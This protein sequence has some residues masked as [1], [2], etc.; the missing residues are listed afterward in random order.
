M[1][2]NIF[3]LTG[4]VAVVAG[5]TSGL[6]RAI[7]IGLAQAGANVVPSGR[8]HEQIDEVCRAVEAEGGETLRHP[9]DILDR[10]SIDALR[11]A[12]LHRFGAV[13][14]LVNAAGRTFRK[15][16]HEIAEGE[17]NDLMNTNL[18]GMLRACQSFYEP[19]KANQRGRIVNIASLSSFVSLFE[20]TAYSA[21]KSAVLSLTRSLALEWARVGVNVN[22]IA[23]GVF[24]TR[25]EFQTPRR[26]RPRPRIP[27]PHPHEALR[28]G[29]GTRRR[30]RPPLLRRRQLPHRPMH[31]RRRRLPLLRRQLLTAPAHHIHGSIA[32]GSK[33][34]LS[35]DD[36]TRNGLECSQDLAR[37]HADYR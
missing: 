1:A 26:H 22:A 15:P 12:V 25:S 29:R 5:G 37:C 35:A 30:R 33:A 11:D 2:K 9:F 10:S 32:V 4:R 31:R 28:Q 34:T 3:D 17:W 23:P 8:R 14:I 36:G 21:S 13:D 16:T 18:T 7:A 6:G 19:L 27:P 20:V 24:R